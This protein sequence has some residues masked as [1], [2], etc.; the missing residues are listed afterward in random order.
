MDIR[1]VTE[2]GEDGTLGACEGGCF[3]SAGDFLFHDLGDAYIVHLVRI[4]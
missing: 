3:C 2:F 4:H 1:T